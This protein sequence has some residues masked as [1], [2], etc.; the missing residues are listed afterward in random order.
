MRKLGMNKTIFRRLLLGNLAIVLLGL[1]A[2]GIAISMMVKGYLYD[3]TQQELLRKAKK[4]N[5]SIQEFQTADE[6]MLALLT[7]LDQTFD[8]RIWIFNDRGEIIATSTQDEVSVGKSVSGT[9][10]ERVMQGNAVSD[11]LHFEG[12]TEPML[13][14]AV[15]WGKEDAL[16]GGIVLHAPV[17]GVTHAIVQVRETILWVTLFGMLISIAI[18]LYLSRSISRPLQHIAR[19]AAEIGMG[20]Y[21]R[22][23]EAD[24]ADEIDDLASSINS[25]AAKL[26]RMDEERRKSDRMRDDFLANLSH[27][28]RTP[29]TAMQ[30]FL[31]ALQDGLIP[32]EGREK[33]YDVMYQETH[34]MTRLVDDLLD[35][36]KLER[37]EVA[38][39]RH[40]LD[41]APLLRKVAFKF[42]PDA[43]ERELDLRVEADDALPKAYADGDRLEQIVANLVRNAVKFTDRGYILLKAYAEEDKV[44]LEVTD[45][46]VG[47]SEADQARIWERF[48]KADRGRSRKNKGA[49]LGLAIVKELVE[50]HEGT[51]E[52]DSRLEQGSTFRV[53]IPAY[54]DPSEVVVAKIGESS[55]HRTNIFLHKKFPNRKSNDHTFPV[56]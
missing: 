55:V 12:L 29:L 4:V 2:V 25:L 11:E 16:Y 23:L 1:G 47:I 15:P 20:Q 6:N 3:V 33:Y 50:R 9:I 17:N 34:H 10:A 19:T 56:Q 27:E 5:L 8:T 37:E 43:R 22:R 7:F 21:D 39:D 45:T 54:R 53:R 31:E 24:G 28:L 30:G 51:I 14:V 42:E 40:P 49:G 52:V 41:V 38:I 32:E 26:E 46:G 35:L 48:F 36:M 18:V 13:S 44:V